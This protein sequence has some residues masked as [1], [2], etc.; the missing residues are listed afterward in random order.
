MYYA[1]I[2]YERCTRKMCFEGKLQI[3]FRVDQFDLKLF[4]I[5]RASNS[6]NNM[7]MCLSRLTNVFIR[8]VELILTL[9]VKV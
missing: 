3:L 6:I 5:Y 2:L 1:Y 9:A 8:S 7:L 4:V